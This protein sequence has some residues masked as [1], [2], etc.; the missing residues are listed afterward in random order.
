M[1]MVSEVRWV[2]AVAIKT[3][4]GQ[5][6]RGR[7]G[8]GRRVHFVLCEEGQQRVGAPAIV[9]SLLLTTTTMRPIRKMLMR[10][11]KPFLSMI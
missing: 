3:L 9:P 5:C 2:I 11:Q 1:S 6:Q 7:W 8:E 4:S 10:L